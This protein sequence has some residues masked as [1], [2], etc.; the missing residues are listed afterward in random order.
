M[1][2]DTSGLAFGTLLFVVRTTI[3]TPRDLNLRYPQFTLEMQN[4]HILQSNPQNYV[5][6]VS[7]P[8]VTIYEGGKCPHEQ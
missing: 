8:N 2:E 1:D 6:C 3:F 4:L 7:Y 5:D